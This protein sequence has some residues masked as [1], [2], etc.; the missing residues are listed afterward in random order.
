MF[1][2]NIYIETDGNDKRTRYRT[3]K[4]I[5][6]FTTPKG[7]TETRE[8]YGTENT[9]GHGISL[10]AL[11]AALN[12]LVKPC[13]AT[14]YM[15]CQYVTENIRFKEVH[16]WYYNGWNSICGKPIANQ[17]E[18]KKIIRFMEKHE[19]IFADATKVKTH[20]YKK[21]MQY[22]IKKLKGQGI[23]WQQQEIGR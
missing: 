23:E 14:V 18:W 9:T 5:V 22:D 21:R 11:V 12:L 1:K 19:L 15:E 13:E 3:Y 2:V 8:V 6:E 4:A 20:S 16:K 7:K 10:L 17:G